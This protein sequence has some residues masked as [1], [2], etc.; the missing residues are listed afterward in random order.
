VQDEIEA[1]ATK[2]SVRWGMV[3]RAEV[4]ITDGA[5]VLSREGK[6]CRLAVL[7]PSAARLAIVPLDSPPAKHDAPNPGA[8]MI[9]FEVTLEPS[10][11]ARLVVQLV[12]GGTTAAAV[13][14]QPLSSW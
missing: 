12:P 10:A 11:T 14:V 8:K 5:A 7:E 3:T 4:Q 13:N 1:P 2:T 6:A 9:V